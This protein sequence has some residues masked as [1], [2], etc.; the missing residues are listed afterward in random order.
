MVK[1]R[2]IRT[3]F[4]EF[5]DSSSSDSDYHE[6]VLPEDNS[7]E[8][9]EEIIAAREKLKNYTRGWKSVALLQESDNEDEQNAG[10]NDPPDETQTNEDEDVFESDGQIS[11]YIESSDPGSYRDSTEEDPE[12][13]DDA[14][15]KK[16]RFPSFKSHKGIPNF[17][18][19]MLFNSNEDFK[20]AVSN[21]A[22]LTRHDIRFTKNEPDRCRAKCM[23]TFDCPWL[24]YGS[25]DREID[26]F[27][28]KTFNPEHNCEPKRGLKRLT[29]K[30]LIKEFY[31]LIVAHPDKKIRYLKPFMEKKLELDVS[32]GQ[33][34][35]VRKTVLAD[36]EGNCVQEYAKLRD[37]AEEL[38]KSNP[39]TT[40]DLLT[41]RP[42][43]GVDGCFLKDL[44]KGEL[45]TAIGRDGNNQ[46]FPV[47]WVVVMVENTETWTWF[48]N[49]L[50]HDIGTAEGEGWTLISDRQKGL[51]GAVADTW[52][53]A[54]HRFCCRHLYANWCKTFSGRHLNNLFWTLAKSTNRYD[55][56]HNLKQLQEVH[57]EAAKDLML[58][59]PRYW[60][61][62][63]FSTH[64]K[65]DSCDNN[66]C[67]AF[68][69]TILEARNKSIISMLEDIRRA[70]MR[71]IR[72][73]RLGVSKWR[74]D[75]GPLIH[76]KLQSNIRDSHIWTCEWNGGG[77]SYEVKC[78]RSQYVVRLRQGVCTCGAWE[79][80]GIPCAHAVCAIHY[81]GAKAEDYKVLWYKSNTYLR[82]Y[83]KPI[84]PIRGENMWPRSE[85]EQVVPPK[86]RKMPGRPK[87]KRRREMHEV[88]LKN[89]LTRVG[90]SMTCHVCKG[91]GHNARNKKCPGR[92]GPS[93]QKDCRPKS[94]PRKRVMLS[95]L[96]L[97]INP[98]T[99]RSILNPG[100]SMSRIIDRGIQ[101]SRTKNISSQDAAGSGEPI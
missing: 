81:A 68:N 82:A 25:Y 76:K 73:K 95:G 51:V 3:S 15:R 48:L 42:V 37:Y 93:S 92:S 32:L 41:D 67:E 9:D 69:G 19:S 4:S 60:C 17:E 58:V 29:S 1:V 38:L 62:A 5:E 27:Q 12:L 63:F 53:E 40:V 39:G 14:V 6:D 61:K 83:Q 64:S 56:D 50:R 91:K 74:N 80:T 66:L 49:L 26:S 87:K 36:L 22:I 45:L 34:K 84:E 21:Y 78:G 31:D 94:Q 97:Y 13:R 18:L 90:R 23:G 100:T 101:S 28:V 75:W 88:I 30:Y 11:E 20:N 72:D 89:N 79:L 16:S 57:A 85:Q 43:L 77:G 33:C 8:D 71:R 35:R 99:G 65:C 96:G 54:E 7:S 47:A 86:L 46:M 2:A 70:M 59:D 52:S 24:I 10:A 44:V 98:E 55:F